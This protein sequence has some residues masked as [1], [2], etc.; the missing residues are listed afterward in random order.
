MSQ[1]YTIQDIINLEQSVT[2]LTE[3][4]G[5]TFRTDSDLNAIGNK[6]QEQDHY[7]LLTSANLEAFC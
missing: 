7:M 6:I 2:N 3:L 4:E 5:I 1:I